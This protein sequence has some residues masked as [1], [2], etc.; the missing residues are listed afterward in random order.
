MFKSFTINY[1]SLLKTRLFLSLFFT[2]SVYS[3]TNLIRNS[4]F[5]GFVNQNNQSAEGQFSWYNPNPIQ[6]LNDWNTLGSSDYYSS[7]YTPNGYN[8]PHSIIGDS[9]AKHGNAFAGFILFA[10]LYD[11]KEYINQHLTTP[12]IADTTYCLS[13]YVS[14]ADRVTHSIHSIGAHFSNT[15]PVFNGAWS[16]ANPQIV[17]QN[18]FITDTTN[19]VLVQG[20]FTANGGEEYITIGNFNSNANTDTLFVGSS[21]PHPG[22]YR[23]AYYY[24]DS[25][26]MYKNNMPTS[27]SEINNDKNIFITPNPNNGVFELS[28][29]SDEQYDIQITNSHGQTIIKR[30]S[31]TFKT[32]IDLNNEKE[33]LYFVYIK[34][35]NLIVKQSKLLFIK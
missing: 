2:Q 24:I 31:H 30:S 13:F 4:S 11:S 19:W 32:Q 21:N 8:V 3:Q 28:Y 14:R 35:N 34:Q 33:G 23:Y 27:V 26:T 10:G 29:K 1:L 12:L 15:A 5:E 9:Y 16:P 7:A 17:N 6:I 25:V 18:G 20:C 22:A